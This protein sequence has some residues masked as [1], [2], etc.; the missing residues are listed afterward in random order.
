MIQPERIRPL[1]AKARRRG[2]YILYW[3]QASQRTRYNH[4]LEYA[5]E[6]ANQEFLPLV[7]Y[8]GLTDRYPEANLR[9]YAF[10]LEGLA[11]TESFLARRGIK[12]VVRHESPEV[13][14]ILKWRGGPHWPWWIVGT[15]ELSESGEPR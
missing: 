14:V 3:M 9:H 12:L 4:A 8:F 2:D 11:E 7:V 1:N 6:A 13:G 15:Q 10:M 5:I